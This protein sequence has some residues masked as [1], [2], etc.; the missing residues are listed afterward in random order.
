MGKNP[1]DRLR[2]LRDRN[3]AHVLEVDKRRKI[4]GRVDNGKVGSRVH[5]TARIE[6]QIG[7]AEVKEV[8]TEMKTLQRK[9]PTERPKCAHSMKRYRVY[10]NF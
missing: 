6:I 1:K 2:A 9:K 10:D 3:P 7:I 8:E 4:L 5:R